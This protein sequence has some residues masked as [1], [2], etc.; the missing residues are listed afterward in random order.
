MLVRQDR[1]KPLVK[2][3]R[4]AGLAGFQLSHRRENVIVTPSS[5][6]PV[7]LGDGNY[8]ESTPS[9]IYQAGR[10]IV[11]NSVG[12]GTFASLNPEVATISQEGDITRVSE[13]IATFSFTVEG[14]SKVIKVD[15]NNKNA[16]DPV[17]EFVSIVSGTA[18]EHL[19]QQIDNRIDNSMT[20]ATN[21]LLYSSQDHSAPSYTRN[22]N[23]WASDVDLTSISPWNSSGGT[24]KAGV[25]ITPR[26]LLNASHYPFGVGTI[27]RFVTSD[28][29]LVERTVVARQFAPNYSSSTINQPDIVVYTLDSDVPA[30]ISFSKVLP[31]N[32]TNYISAENFAD[33][34]IPALGLDAQEKGTIRDTY[35][36]AQIRFQEP[37]DADRLL[38]YE[39]I[40][41][42]DSG[43][44]VFFILNGELVLLAVWTSGGGGSGSFI[45][46][47]IS[48]V[49]QMIADADA[50]A[51]VST[52]Y[53]LTEADLSSFPTL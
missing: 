24:N 32:Y 2:I 51:G 5:T 23:F 1:S 15:L 41:S 26:H 6:T 9:V 48:M 31:S 38:L 52:G 45:V 19:S 36:N 49:N 10:I 7:V 25:M 35:S 28:N 3:S 46:N 13:G 40:I 8:N 47:Y 22:T 44:P 20:M 14:I 11:S 21:G 53:T 33:T 42:G 12:I 43:N 17:Y 39:G 4:N 50:Q 34:R 27:V 29:T 18:A 37:V 30:G 16:T